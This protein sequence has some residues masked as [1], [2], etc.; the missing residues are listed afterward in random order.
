[1]ILTVS[2]GKGEVKYH[3]Q[4][5]SVTMLVQPVSR[6]RGRAIAITDRGK[7][8]Q[9]SVPR[10]LN[11]SACFDPFRSPLDTWHLLRL[12]QWTRTGTPEV[13]AF[14]AT[15]FICQR[16][17]LYEPRHGHHRNSTVLFP[18]R[19]ASLVNRGTVLARKF[20]WFVR[21]EARK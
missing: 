12:N 11:E 10:T 17:L 13:R 15:P 5:S 7:L 2:Y 20:A 21:V 6:A 18:K 19:P 9:S 16:R 14:L 8:Q 3:G 4:V 1:M